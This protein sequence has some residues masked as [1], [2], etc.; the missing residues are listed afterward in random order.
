MVDF[1]F[2]K[3]EKFKTDRWDVFCKKCR[4]LGINP[5]TVKSLPSEDKSSYALVGKSFGDVDV[6]KLKDVTEVSKE[7]GVAFGRSNKPLS[8]LKR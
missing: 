6:M 8:K 1:T 7:L 2:G 5:E 4:E 3:S